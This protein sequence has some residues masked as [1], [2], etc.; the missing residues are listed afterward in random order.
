MISIL[1]NTICMGIMAYCGASLLEIGN[2]KNL[3]SSNDIFEYL[4][5]KHYRISI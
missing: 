3:K 5:G 2:K 4:C 1:S